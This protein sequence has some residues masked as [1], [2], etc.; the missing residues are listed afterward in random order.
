MIPTLEGIELE[1]GAW[2]L[3]YFAFNG[4]SDQEIPDRPW[5]RVL[6]P[7]SR[8]QVEEL[9]LE[10]SSDKANVFNE[11]IGK[12]VGIQL[13]FKHLALFV[14]H[15]PSLD[16]AGTRILEKYLKK[17][18]KLLGQRFDDLRELIVKAMHEFRPA[19]SIP[20]EV[21]DALLEPIERLLEELD[22]STD[23]TIGLAEC[24]AKAAQFQEVLMSV[25]ALRVMTFPG[26]LEMGDP[27]REPS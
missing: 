1:A 7:L 13:H 26:A 15:I 5:L 27:M 6:Q 4:S 2:V 24:E 10:V 11:L 18:G 8:D 9:G 16:N 14:A 21:Q 22:L 3:P 19:E 23:Q 17:S 12:L 25:G 20:Q